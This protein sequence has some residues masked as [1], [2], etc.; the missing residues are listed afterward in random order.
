GAVA[1]G[2]SMWTSFVGSSRR[3]TATRLC[4]ITMSPTQA[5]ATTNVFICVVGATRA[6][7]REL[8]HRCVP[9]RVRVAF[10]PHLIEVERLQLLRDRTAFAGADCATIELADRQHFG[11]RAREECF[12]GD[13]NLVARNAALRAGKPKLLRQREDRAPGDAVEARR[14]LRRVDPAVAHDED[15]L[16]RAFGHV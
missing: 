12:V 15:V 5:G 14:E 4:A 2:A 11:G 7:S 6:F 3:S 9:F 8:R 1:A 13:V 16:S 10:T